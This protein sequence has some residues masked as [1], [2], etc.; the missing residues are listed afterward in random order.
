MHARADK[1][2]PE[3]ASVLDLTNTRKILDVGGGSG[4]F[5]FAMIRNNPEIHATIFDLQNIIPLTLKYIEAS[6]L[7]GQVDTVVGDYLA[8]SLGIGYD[9]VFMSAIIHI[10]SAEENL[11]LIRNGADAL[12]PGGQLIILDHIMNDDRTE[13]LVG[14]IFALNMLVGTFHGDTYTRREIESWMEQSGLS[15][16]RHQTTPSGIQMLT[17]IKK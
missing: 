5:S 12:Y 7:S 13:P 4:A 15:K 6:W 3:V 17:G 10:N 11:L 9:L 16:I 14:T 1:Q 8:D 2:A